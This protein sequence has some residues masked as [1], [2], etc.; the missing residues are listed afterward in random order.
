MRFTFYT[1]K[2]VPQCLSAINE[3]IKG[4]GRSG[5]EGW[6]DRTGGTFSIAVSTRVARR[7]TRKTHLQAKLERESGVTII[8]GFVPDGVG[9]QGQIVIFG[10]L[11]LVGFILL[12]GGNA[13]LALVAVV[14]GAVLYVPLSGDH[15]NSTVLLREVRSLLKAKD[16]PPSRK[17]PQTGGAAPRTAAPAARPRMPPPARGPEPP[18]RGPTPPRR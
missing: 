18:G 14:A 7:F 4:G 11:L 13:L 10:M 9:L 1:D 17:A 15:H 2:T 6:V 3:R 12:A 5:F 16:R 8:R